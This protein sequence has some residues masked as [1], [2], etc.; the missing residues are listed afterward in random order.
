MNFAYAPQQL[1]I[2]PVYLGIDKIKFSNGGIDH[3]ACRALQADQS[4]Y[5]GIFGVAVLSRFPIKR[6]LAFQLKTQPYDWYHDEIKKPDFL[7]ITRH[8]TTKS[9]FHFRPVCEVKWLS[10]RCA[11]R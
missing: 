8:E 6:A 7:E 2:D 3:D 10:V 5:K 1:E 4:E 11:E 9:L